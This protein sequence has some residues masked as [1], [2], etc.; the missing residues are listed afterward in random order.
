MV[1]V[2]GM[3]AETTPTATVTAAAPTAVST[4]TTAAAAAATTTAVTTRVLEQAMSWAL[5]RTSVGRS[6]ADSRRSRSTPPLICS[7]A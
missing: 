6:S 3:P 7:R 1:E 4:P 2:V 5:R